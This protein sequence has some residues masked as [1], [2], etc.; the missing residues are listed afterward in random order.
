[1]LNLNIEIKGRTYSDLEYALQEVMKKVKDEFKSGMDSNETGSY[2]FDTDGQEGEYAVEDQHG[3]SFYLTSTEA[4]DIYVEYGNG[5]NVDEYYEN[6]NDCENEIRNKV[7]QAALS[8]D[9]QFETP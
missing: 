7:Y 9:H 2:S 4:H 6:P 1:M 8:D 3:D 5:V